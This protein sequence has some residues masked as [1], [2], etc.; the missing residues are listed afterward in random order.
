MAKSDKAK[1]GAAA[2]GF[3][4]L[5]AFVAIPLLSGAA[6]AAS[7]TPAATS[8]SP[9]TGWQYGGQGW[10]DNEFQFGSTTVSWNASFGWVV[11][12]NVTSTGPGTWML[13]EQR[14]VG[15]TLV[16]SYSTPNAQGT[17]NYHGQEVDVAFANL[18]NHSTVYVNGTP[19]PALGITNASASVN[20]SISESITKTVGS[21]TSSASLNVAGVGQAATSFEPSLGLIPLNLTGVDEWNST[22][23]SSPSASWNISYAWQEHGFNG[24]TNQG[25]GSNTGSLSQTGTV[26]LTGFKLHLPPTPFHDGKN[27]TAVLLVVQGVF[28]T[29]DGFIWIPHAFNLFGT[30]PH[31]YDSVSL[32]S[33]GISAETLYV[34]SGATGISVTAAASTFGTSAQAV[35]SLASPAGGSSPAA[36]SNAP[37]ATILAQPMTY[38][39]AKAEAASL[40]GSTSSPSGAAGGTAGLLVLLVGVAVA[41]IVGTVGVIEWRSY[42]QRRSQKGLVGGY[43]ASWPNGVPPGAAAAP[44]PAGPSQGKFPGDDSARRP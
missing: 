39:Q 36:G 12:F 21:R 19:V 11:I 13:E 15:I 20:A 14:T 10:S 17:Y 34:S 28:D 31:G 29:Y 32:G 9:S 44:P 4:L 35:N 33:A 1:F 8:T 18:T 40:T 6:S 27:R 25:S 26:S 41:V 16:A 37:G 23:T 2:A 24:T 43:S 30:A 42:A 3:V 7:A 38:G 22:A 5:L